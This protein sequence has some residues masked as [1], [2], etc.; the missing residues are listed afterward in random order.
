MMK[1]ITVLL[2][3]VALSSCAS[4]TSTKTWEQYQ[5]LS[6]HYI[7]RQIKAREVFEEC[8][9]KESNSRA[10]MKAPAE[11]VAESALGA[12]SYQL[13]EY[14]SATWWLF[15]HMASGEDYADLSILRGG[16]P[17][18]QAAYDQRLV[19]EVNNLVSEQRRIAIRNILEVR[20]LLAK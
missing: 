4:S 14:R 3:S 10:L 20:A 11:T 18:R 8:V 9:T 1:R 15:N 16:N 13:S 6:Q 19:N 17:V 7:M 2:L 12:C 5:Q